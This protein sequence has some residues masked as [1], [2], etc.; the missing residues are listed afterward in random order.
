MRFGK[1]PFTLA[2]HAGESLDYDSEVRTDSISATGGAAP[3]RAA[4][5]VLSPAQ[6]RVLD[7]LTDGLA[8][9]EIAVRLSLSPHTVHNDQRLIYIERRKW[10]GP[11]SGQIQ[12]TGPA[13]VVDPQ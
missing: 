8:E 4:E 7:L 2:I 3:A 11:C 6:Q 9:K 12:S 5:P 1:V 13:H 10:R